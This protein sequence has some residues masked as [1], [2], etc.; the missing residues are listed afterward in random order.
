MH[1]ALELGLAPGLLPGRVVLGDAGQALTSTWGAVPATRGLDATGILRAAADGK[2]HALVLLYF[3]N[4]LPLSKHFHVITSIPNTFFAKL[5]APGAIAP[6]S[7]LDYKS[8]RP[9]AKSIRAAVINGA[10]GGLV[11]ETAIIEACNSGKS[12]M[13]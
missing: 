7:L 11:E 12:N 2:I 4:E 3:L 13:A 9:W 8:A 5:D 1:G 6:M 10:R